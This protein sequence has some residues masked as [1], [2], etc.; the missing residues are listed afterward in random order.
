M[1]E[2]VWILRHDD[3]CTVMKV[4]ITKG[5]SRVSAV[6]SSRRRTEAWDPSVILGMF[7]VEF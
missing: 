3:V 4:Q 2:R 6:R 5:V 1:G 7:Q